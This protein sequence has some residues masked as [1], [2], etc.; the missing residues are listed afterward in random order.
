MIAAA[1]VRAL[2]RLTRRRTRFRDVSVRQK[3]EFEQALSLVRQDSAMEPSAGF[4]FSRASSA[5]ED[6]TDTG[7]VDPVSVA[8]E[9]GRHGRRL[10]LTEVSD[11]DALSRG[12]SVLE[13]AQRSLHMIEDFLGYQRGYFFGSEESEGGARRSAVLGHGAATRRRG[14]DGPEVSSGSGRVGDARDA[15]AA[16]APASARNSLLVLPRLQPPTS[17]EDSI[18]QAEA[19][20]LVCVG[21]RLRDA[22]GRPTTRG[23][24]DVHGWLEGPQRTR[25]TVCDSG[26]DEL[27]LVAFP[28]RVGVYSARVF[29]GGASVE[30][31]ESRIRM[32]VGQIDPFLATLS[33]PSEAARGTRVPMKI[34]AR[35]VAGNVR[36]SPKDGFGVMLRL[37]MNTPHFSAEV[38]EDGPLP[39]G[40]A[41]PE[42]SASLVLGPTGAVETAES[43]SGRP[44]VLRAVVS[45]LQSGTWAISVGHKVSRMSTWLSRVL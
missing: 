36:V 27:L 30:A 43:E 31:V 18:G 37:G 19:G 9:D 38:V 6:A 33:A 42:G 5:D 15:T 40:D 13:R 23:A 17:P 22:E 11:A 20:V 39:D 24:V 34:T 3:E 35:D 16:T 2:H 25:F 8:H 29:I 28:T 32:Y 7:P 10:V 41:G 45:G 44:Y 12:V 21:L 14:L 4:G 1:T 26:S